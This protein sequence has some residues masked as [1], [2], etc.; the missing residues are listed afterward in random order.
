MHTYSFNVAFG[1]TNV[2]SITINANNAKDAV[3]RMSERLV[4]GG[5]FKMVSSSDDSI[6]IE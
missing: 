4:E 5:T 1:K 3:T 2:F 6:I